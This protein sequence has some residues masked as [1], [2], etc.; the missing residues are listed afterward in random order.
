MLWSLPL[1]VSLLVI[2]LA[3]DHAH[4]PAVETVAAARAVVSRTSLRV[5]PLLLLERKS[6]IDFRDL[7]LGLAVVL[8]P[9]VMMSVALRNAVRAC[10]ST[11][12]K[13]WPPLDLEKKKGAKTAETEETETT[14]GTI[15][16]AGTGVIAAIPGTTITRIQMQTAIITAGTRDGAEARE[17]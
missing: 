9:A 13:A 7:G 2:S 14:I 1:L 10:Q 3:A 11:S 15:E 16:I 12:A 4:A 17:M 5:E 6:L 8:I